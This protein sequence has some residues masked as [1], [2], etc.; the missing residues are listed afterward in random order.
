VA[1]P[2]LLSTLGEQGERARST[3]SHRCNRQVSFS[4]TAAAMALMELLAGYGGEP[5]WRVPF[6]TS[7]VLVTTLPHSEA[8][9]PYA[10]IA[11]HLISCLA[12]LGAVHVLG[13]GHVASAVGVGLAALGM[14]AARAPH[15]PAGI[16]AFLIAANGLTLRW[17]VSPVMVG[18]CSW[19]RFLKAGAR[20]R[21]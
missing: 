13:P 18:L 3:R 15:P 6:V 19:W 4:G 7:I 17:V 10:V 21:M 20:Q 9:R 8:S 1:P 12:G 5:L 11:G 16:D 14:L 2:L